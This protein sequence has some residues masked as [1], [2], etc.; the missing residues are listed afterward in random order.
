MMTTPMD[1]PPETMHIRGLWGRLKNTV[2]TVEGYTHGTR[3][4][5]ETIQLGSIVRGSTD[6]LVKKPL[7]LGFTNPVSPMQ[8]SKELV[9]GAIV[10]AK[11]K[12]P[13]LYAPEALAGGP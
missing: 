1:V 3:S 10:Y 4:A 5:E 2:K 8:L 12:Q 7:L 6:A 11:Y 13:V 9:D